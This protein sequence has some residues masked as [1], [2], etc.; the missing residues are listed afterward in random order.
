MASLLQ[1]LGFGKKQSNKQL[2]ELLPAVH[3]FIDCLVR[4]GPSGQVCFEGAGIKTITVSK[5][6]GM[7]GGQTA[8]F[9]YTTA[10]G[11]YSFASSVTTVSDQQA[12]LAMPAEIKVLQRFAGARQRAGV[13]IDTTV[14]A[15]W[16]FTPVGRIATD[17]Q[18][19][20]LSDL[21]RGGAQLTV[22]RELKVGE[23][24][25]VNMQLAAKDPVL[26]K[27]EVRRVEKTRTGKFN[28]GL[29]FVEV[30]PEAE[31]AITEFINRRQMDLRN[32]GLA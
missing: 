2:R 29:R 5:L 12:T 25:D 15:Q 13:R 26:V 22:D 20:T 4:G 31:R 14:N 17:F 16:R 19:A 10:S 32:R 18:K 24:V 28:A 27:G 7:K 11:K 1:M 23:K 8:I 30:G 3:S 21:S 6:D 9:T